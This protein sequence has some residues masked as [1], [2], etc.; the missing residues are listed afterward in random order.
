MSNLLRTALLAV[1]LAASFM[2]LTG[3]GD[4][5]GTVQPPAVEPTPP[6]AGPVDEPPSTDEK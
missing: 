1:S 4:T 6:T 2:L 5:G 3:C